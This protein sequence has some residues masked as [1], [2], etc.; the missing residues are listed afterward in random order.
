[1]T[2][3]IVSDVE[4][5]AADSGVQVFRRLLFSRQEAEAITGLLPPSE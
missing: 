4:R 5:S 3:K 2:A 1:L